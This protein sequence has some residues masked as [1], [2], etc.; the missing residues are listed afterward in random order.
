MEIPFLADSLVF[1]YAKNFTDIGPDQF[2]A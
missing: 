2:L 1:N